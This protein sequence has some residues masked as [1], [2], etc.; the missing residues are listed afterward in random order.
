[1]LAQ[2]PEYR[3]RLEHVVAEILH[4]AVAMLFLKKVTERPA[5]DVVPSHRIHELD[6]RRTLGTDGVIDADLRGQGSVGFEPVSDQI[7]MQQTRP[8]H[9][10]QTFIR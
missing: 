2:A 5:R 6:D 1:M 8:D 10:I 4:K 9:F 7:Q 3:A